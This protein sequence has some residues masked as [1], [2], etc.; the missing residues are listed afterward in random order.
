MLGRLAFGR[1]LALSLTAVALASLA[2]GKS[3]AAHGERAQEGFL[4]MQTIG[5]TDVTF[6]SDTL[7]PGQDLTIS[8]T[9][10]VLD[11]WPKSLADPT[12]G[13]VSVDTPGPVVLMKNR[14]V[15]GEPAAD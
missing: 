12:I 2:A 13:Y 11:P 6:S 5:F 4:R 14:L 1:R 8:G 15:N 3:A 10:T 9:A 7:Q